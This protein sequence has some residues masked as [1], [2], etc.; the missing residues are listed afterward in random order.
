MPKTNTK[1]RKIRTNK[2]RTRR[3]KLLK[4]KQRQRRRIETVFGMPFNKLMG[5][6]TPKSV[7]TPSPSPKTIKSL[8]SV[9]PNLVPLSQRSPHVQSLKTPFPQSASPLNVRYTK[10]GPGFMAPNLKDIRDC[11]LINIEEVCN[12]TE[13]CKWDHERKQCD[14]KPIPFNINN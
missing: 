10:S 13:D 7:R 6:T 5:P 14:L 2:R 12:S 3:R 11:S 8:N 9:T 4:E 1:K